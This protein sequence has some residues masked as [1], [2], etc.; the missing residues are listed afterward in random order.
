MSRDEGL[1]GRKAAHLEI[2]TDPAI[3]LETGES[4]FDHLSF[5]HRSLPELNWSDLDTHTQF[6]GRSVR[7]PLFISSMTGGSDEGYRLNKELA[8]A[9]QQ[10]RIPVGMGSIRIL[11][12]KP[13]VFEHFRLRD[14]APDVPLWANI[15]AQQLVAEA[16][17]DRFQSL[18]ELTKRL[19]VDAVA[20]H[21][22]PGQELFQD[23]GDRDFRGLKEA[24]KRYIGQAGLPVIV[25]ETGF[26]I[27][28][29]EARQLWKAGAAYID[30]AGTGGT[31]WLAVEAWRSSPETRLAAEAFDSWGWPTAL[32][33]AVL[34]R[35]RPTPLLA[36][37]GLRTG[38]DLAKALAWGAAAGGMALPFIRAAQEKGHE[39][40]LAV[41]EGIEKALLTTMLLS[42]ARSLDDLRK[43]PLEVSPRFADALRRHG[44]RARGV[45]R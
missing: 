4:W 26:G 42:G 19:E 30:T 27:A 1:A 43:V 7:L 33:T 29:D 44:V 24:L 13:E 31:N 37:G 40:V 20:V 11:F 34:G 21:L 6:L 38:L 5:E 28:P 8:R 25:K 17:K 18:K 2:C 35:R 14:L 15:G 39:G 16:E 32:L 9:A 41:I 36:S 12:R 22:N 3:N 23:E 45:S 10:A